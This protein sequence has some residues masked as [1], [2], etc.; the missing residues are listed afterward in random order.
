[1]ACICFCIF[2]S[3]HACASPDYLNHSLFLSLFLCLCRR[4][5]CPVLKST[6]KPLD[7]HQLIA[8]KATRFNHI[9]QV[10]NVPPAHSSPFHALSAPVSR[11]RNTS[12]RP[13][14]HN[15]INGRRILA[16]WPTATHCHTTWHSCIVAHT[17]WHRFWRWPRTCPLSTWPEPAG[18]PGSSTCYD[19][20]WQVN[21]H[22]GTHCPV[23]SGTHTNG[24]AHN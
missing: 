1:M 6:R 8:S 20:M 16:P 23:P 22:N 18:L 17:S 9:H 4:C 24:S 11:I 7:L 10:T 3:V 5:P 13:R 12:A 21:S 15:C 2:V 19:L 14:V